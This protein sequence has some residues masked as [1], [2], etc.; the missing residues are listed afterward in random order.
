MRW[1]PARAGIF[2]YEGEGE[3]LNCRVYY[4]L[5]CFSTFQFAFF[6]FIYFPFQG[7]DGP[8]HGGLGGA[9]A[10]G[11]GIPAVRDPAD[12][13]DGRVGLRGSA[14]MQVGDGVV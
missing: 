7:C 1:G 6:S 11:R 4:Y 10:G 9:A 2:S 5:L 14:A 12:V 3:L 8:R 13:T